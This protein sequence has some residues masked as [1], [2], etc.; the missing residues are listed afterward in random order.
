MDCGVQSPW[1]MFLPI[2]YR[3]QDKIVC[4]KA[5]KFSLQTL[6]TSMHK[7][8]SLPLNSFCSIMVDSK[9]HACKYKTLKDQ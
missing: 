8:W 7:H 6:L 9:C 3:M 5:R 2:V 4:S 1:W